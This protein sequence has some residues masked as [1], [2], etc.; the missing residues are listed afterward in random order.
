MS[1]LC[2]FKKNPI[3]YNSIVESYTQKV[4]SKYVQYKSKDG[5]NH[6]AGRTKREICFYIT[7]V[8]Q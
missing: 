2:P 1:V 3:I 7:S 8:C 4:Y 6:E 5:G